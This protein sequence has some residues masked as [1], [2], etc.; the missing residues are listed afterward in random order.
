MN[1]IDLKEL[2]KSFRE[3][4]R[5]PTLLFQDAGHRI[6][7]LGIPEAS[8]FRP[9]TY[10]IVDNDEAILVDPGGAGSFEFV[11]DRVEQILPPER[12][13]ALVISHLDPDVAASFP[14]W[15]DVNPACKVLA[16]MRTLTLLSYFRDFS[17]ERLNVEEQP[18]F[19]FTS[20]KAVQFIPSPFLPSP[21]A[22]AT[23]DTSSKFLFSGDIWASLELEWTLVLDDFAKHEMRLNLFHFDHMASN[24]ATKGFVNRIRHLELDAILPQHGRI[25]P[26]EF[27]PE[28]LDYL[29]RLHCGLDILYPDLAN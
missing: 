21:G 2:G 5:E 12:I 3:D 13:M 8:A 18:E 19:R 16:S 29:E 6:F 14:F 24:K 25:I 4:Y 28:A 9:N 20:G 23:Y 17:F 10:L 7:W 27:I 15:V 26:R 11:R 22:F 1:S